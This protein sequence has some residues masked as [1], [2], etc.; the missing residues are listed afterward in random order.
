MALI[1]RSMQ[2]LR[3]WPLVSL[4]AVMLAL[5]LGAC[6]GDDAGSAAPTAG[7]DSSAT[8]QDTC[9]RLA[10]LG[11]AILGAGSAQ[12]PDDVRAAVEE[13]FQSFVDEADASGDDQLTELA[14]LAQARFDVYLT[15]ADGLDAREAGNDADIALDRA[16][17][18]CLEL[19]ATTEFPEEPRG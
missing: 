15:S 19:G 16:I 1:L 6:G 10:D 5:A 2:P 3:S 13:P 17:Q 4:L 14:H 11:E 7:S 12:T 18:R 8:V 9:D